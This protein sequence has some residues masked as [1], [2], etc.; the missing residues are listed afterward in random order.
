MNIKEVAKR[1]R[2]STATVSRTINGSNKVSPETARR[3]MRCID[4]A[5][6]PQAVQH[7]I[8]RIEVVELP[9]E[10]DVGV[11]IA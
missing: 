8:E 3:P 9:T 7:E 11:L 1:A 4:C 2:L 6:S 5:V 10:G